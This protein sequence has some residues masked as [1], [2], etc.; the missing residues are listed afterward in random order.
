[1]K[2]SSQ[3]GRGLSGR[4]MIRFSF[5]KEIVAI[6]SGFTLWSIKTISN[7]SKDS[8]KLFVPFQQQIAMLTP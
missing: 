7:E 2:N 8:M 6:L 1:M 4:L 3:K 5:S